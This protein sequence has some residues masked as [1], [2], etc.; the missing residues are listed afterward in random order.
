M[1]PDNTR[2]FLL[3]ASRSRLRRNWPTGLYSTVV[4]GVTYYRYLDPVT[5]SFRGLGSDFE[6]ARQAAVARNN[7]ISKTPVQRYVDKLNGEASVAFAKACDAWLSTV[8]NRKSGRGDDVRERSESTLR[9]Y[10][11]YARR[12]QEHFG[13]D[14]AI[15]KITLRDVSEYLDTFTDAGKM[16]AHNMARGLLVQVWDV[17]VAKGW[18]KTNVPDQ[19]LKVTHEVQRKRLTVPQLESILA[20]AKAEPADAWF[21]PAAR[22]ALYCDQRRQ[23]VATVPKSAWKNK[24]LTVEQD[25]DEQG[26]PLEMKQ[27]KTG[28]VVRVTVGPLLRAAITECLALKPSNA[29]TIIRKPGRR[30]PVSRDMLTKTFQRIRDDLIAR[31]HKAW[32]GFTPETPGKPSWHELRSLGAHLAEQAGKNAKDLAGHETDQMAKTYQQGH[33][34]VYEAE[35]L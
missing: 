5:K 4:K 2:G 21:D 18:T 7:A 15:D 9:D 17:A 23:D 35:S 3:P 32:K 28:H 13:A 27:S 24:A 14:K 34:K 11:G 25:A 29:S 20:A 33:T 6:V 31:K 26:H 1:S 22:F 8:R 19:T 12:F 30:K 16:R 10:E